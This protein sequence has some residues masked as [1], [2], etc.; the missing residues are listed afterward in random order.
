MLNIWG[1]SV[2]LCVGIALLEVQGIE[3]RINTWEL[4]ILCQLDYL[5]TNPPAKPEVPQVAAEKLSNL[6]KRFEKCTAGESHDCPAGTIKMQHESINVVKLPQSPSQALAHKKLQRLNK[7]MM[8]LRMQFNRHAASVEESYSSAVRH[9]LE[10]VYGS[11]VAGGVKRDKVDAVQ[12]G[13]MFKP[14]GEDG[15]MERFCGTGEAAKGAGYD[16]E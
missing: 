7:R 12:Q 10:S 15:D 8:Q 6:L 14:S 9:L 1:L 11:N 5:G 16:I 3:T 2:L 4:N 13:E